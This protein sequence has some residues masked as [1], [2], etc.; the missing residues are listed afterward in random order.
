[1]KKIRPKLSQMLR[2][3]F[4]YSVVR[5]MSDAKGP[6]INSAVFL[7]ATTGFLYC[8]STAHAGGYLSSLRLDSDVLDRNFHQVLYNGFLIS[9]GQVL[10]ALFAYAAARVLYSHVFLPSLTDW[11]RKSAKNKRRYLKAKRSW[12]GKRKSTAIERAH[13]DRTLTA[14]S[15]CALGMTFILSLAYFE[16]QGKKEALAIL[17]QIEARKP[18]DVSNLV[19]VRIE[20]QVKSL[21]YL[22]CGAR[23][24]AAIDLVSKTI[25]Y[26]PQSGHSY[27][28]AASVVASAPTPSSAANRAP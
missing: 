5:S 17:K 19:R 1:M 9:F 6:L 13:K 20:D 11:L 18:A 15:Y 22:Y 27:Q 23:N 2:I 10:V 24:C 26:F 8:V 3:G 16:V 28:F 21:Y 12:I 25:F 4:S 7:A 14:I